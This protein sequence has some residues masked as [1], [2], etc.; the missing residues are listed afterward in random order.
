MSAHAVF[1]TCH[2]DL[3]FIFFCKD[4]GIF[5]IV[6]AGDLHD[7][8]H[9]RAVQTTDIVDR[10]AFLFLLEHVACGKR[11]DLHIDL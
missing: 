5:D 2:G 7:A 1:H 9:R 3:E 8:I 4:Q 6:D 11:R 10:S